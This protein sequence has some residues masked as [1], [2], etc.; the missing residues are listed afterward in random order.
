MSDGMRR[1]CTV[2][3]LRQRLE[4]VRPTRRIGHGDVPCGRAMLL[5]VAVAAGCSTAPTTCLVSG[6]VAVDDVPVTY[7]Y[8]TLECLDTLRPPCEVH[9]AGGRFAVGASDRLQPGRY[10]VRVNAVRERSVFTPPELLPPGTSPPPPADSSLVGPSWHT[11]S[12]M[13]VTLAL[14]VN[15]VDIVGPA[16]GAPRVAS[17]R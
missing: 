2:L 16:S 13:E 9:I 10:R 4:D 7:G 15:R 6:S 5:L 11:K 3:G 12:D 17:G 1:D 14:G 8:L